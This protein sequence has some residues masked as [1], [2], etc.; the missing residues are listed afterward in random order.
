MRK[1]ISL[2][3]MEWQILKI[4]WKDKKT[5]VKDVWNRLFPEGEKAYTTI[6]TYMDR[7]VD[8]KILKKE[9]IGLVNFY[10]QLLSE[11]DALDFATENLVD[12]AFQG[13]FGHLATYL[14]GSRRLK[15]SD[16]EK[17]KKM[18]SEKEKGLQ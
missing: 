1:K 5:T 17:I 18:I 11:K 16:L 7:M 15:T 9:K 12:R 6:Q 14:I 13:S 3:E 10:E 2:S 4:I 8:K